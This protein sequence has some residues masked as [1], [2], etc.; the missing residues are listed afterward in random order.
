M[1]GGETGVGTEQKP[2]SLTFPSPDIAELLRERIVQAFQSEEFFVYALGM[3][4][5]TYQIRKDDMVFTLTQE[6]DSVQ[7]SAPAKYE[8]VARFILLEELLTM[9]DLA[10]SFERMHNLDGMKSDLLKGVFDADE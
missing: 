10:K 2:I 5:P 6:G 4:P 3:D 7:L 9:Q 8:H 1:R